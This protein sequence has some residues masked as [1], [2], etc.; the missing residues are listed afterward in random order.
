MSRAGSIAMSTAASLPPVAVF[1]A[2]ALPAPLFAALMPSQSS[3]MGI[4]DIL[5]SFGTVAAPVGIGLAIAAHV[6]GKKM[7]I[8]VG[9]MD[10]IILSRERYMMRH[11]LP[12]LL[13]LLVGA[14]QKISQ[15]RATLPT[16]QNQINTDEVLLILTHLH[17]I[18]NA[19]IS[20]RLPKFN[21]TEP[22]QEIDYVIKAITLGNPRR[23]L[24]LKF[25]RTLGEIRAAVRARMVAPGGAGSAAPRRAPRTL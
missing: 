24:L 18:R 25:E 17:A 12:S 3:A 19:I 13:T 11:E 15:I 21:N 5:T 10:K 7:G 4:W 1:A 6:L 8:L 16:G 9:R 20:T 2:I 23:D 14:T 22:L